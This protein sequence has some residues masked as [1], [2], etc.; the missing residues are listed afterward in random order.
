MIVRAAARAE[1]ERIAT[2]DLQHGT[3]LDGVEIVDPFR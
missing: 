1:C 3:R 2:E